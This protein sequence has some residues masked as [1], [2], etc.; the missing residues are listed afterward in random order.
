MPALAIESEVVIEAPA[1][2]VWRT[3]TEPDQISQWFADRVELVLEPGAHGYMQFG[4]QGG[5]VVVE[6]V[7][8]PTRFSY[9]W[10]YPDGEEP[11]AGN[12][13]LV[14]FTL[15]PEGEERTRLRVVESGHEGRAWPGPDKQRYA[16]EHRGGWAEY[17]G[18][19]ADL[20]GERRSR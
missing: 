14:E 16:D 9:R 18:R 13:I 5:P 11:V 15:T 4:D 10:N 20:I 2:V 8:P 19:L 17:M 1:E 7:D 12:S 3:I 6:T